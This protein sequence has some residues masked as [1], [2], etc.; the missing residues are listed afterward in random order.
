MPS[1]CVCGGG[2]CTTTCSLSAPLSRLSGP[3]LTL[4]RCGN[5]QD[6]CSMSS[7]IKPENSAV[8][9][10]PWWHHAIHS[11]RLL[12]KREKKRNLS[13][14]MVVITKGG[15]SNSGRQQKRWL[16]RSILCYSLLLFQYRQMRG[17]LFLS[18]SALTWHFEHLS[19]SLTWGLD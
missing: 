7:L 4:M 1:G 17:T 5:T 15:S 3:Y 14:T 13:C 18:L 19:D 6:T 8:S 9:C 16:K 11:K 12:Y 10:T 2:N